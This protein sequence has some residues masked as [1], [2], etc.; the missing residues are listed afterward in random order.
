MNPIYR[1]FLGYTGNLAAQDW[2]D[3]QPGMA[4]NNRGELFER[5]GRNTSGKVSI[6]AGTDMLVRFD[7]PGETDT[8]A[9]Y[10]K[11]DVCLGMTYFTP[12]YTPPAGTE[13]IRYCI[14]GEAY[15][16]V[17]FCAGR[18]TLPVYKDDLAVEYA[19]ESGEQFF[20]AKL[21]GSL[22][23]LG[24]DY[25]AIDGAPF[26]TRFILDITGSTDGGKTWQEVFKGQFY[27]T[28]C[29]FD[30]DNA[31]VE[32]EPEVRDEY[33]DVL[34]GLEN[35]YNLIKLAP[36]VRKLMYYKRPMV[37]VY[38]MGSSKITCILGEILNWETDATATTSNSDL[39]DKFFFERTAG[40]IE[41]DLTY[42]RSTNNF[43][44][45]VGTYAGN[46]IFQDGNT[47]STTWQADL[48]SNNREYYLHVKSYYQADYNTFYL[49]C[50]LLKAN[51]EQIAYK[52]QIT[53]ANPLDSR[54]FNLDLGITDCNALIKLIYTRLVC[55]TTT[56]EGVPTSPIP[57]DDITLSG[58]KN[59]HY[60]VKYLL[61]NS[62]ISA[63]YSETPTEWG[64]RSDG[65][66][67]LP[68]DDSGLFL[69]LDESSWGNASMWFKP[70]PTNAAIERNGRASYTL[71]D[72]Y[73]V[74]DSIAV[75]LKQ[76]APGITHEATEEYSE[77]FYGE[78]TGY[79]KEVQLLLTQK[80]NITRSDYTQAA[81]NSSITLR[82]LLDMFKNVFRAYW[83]IED[84]KLRIEGIDYFRNGGSYDNAPEVGIDL[85]QMRNTRNGK[86]WSLGTSKYKFEKVDM[87]ERYEFGWMDEVSEPF[88][89]LPL[90]VLS[91]YVS[92]GK[93]EEINVSNFTSDIDYMLLNPGEISNDGFALFYAVAGEAIDTGIGAVELSAEN[94][95]S[96]K[97]IPVDG[98]FQGVQAEADIS[99]LV[100]GSASLVFLDGSGNALSPEYPIGAGGARYKVDCRIPQAAASVAI[101]ATGTVTAYFYGLLAYGL[102]QLPFVNVTM[103]GVEY[104]LQNGNLAF[105]SLQEAYWRRDMPAPK[106][107]INGRETEA[108][109]IEKKK[110]QEVTYPAP[111]MTCDPSKLVRTGIGDGQIKETSITLSSLTAKTTL[112]Y[113][114]E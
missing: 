70:D 109:S 90:E 82:Q 24:R 6:P 7:L 17:E 80:T 32:V 18:Y 101:R 33:T 25:A 85:T 38:V 84:G 42:S 76:F 28:D 41:A 94:G 9:A 74:A 27:K 58:N 45:L 46:I 54:V 69:P 3:E 50:A 14:Y 2:P 10:G 93:K 20:R 23:F 40:T 19:Q 8:I 11:G 114:T 103:D 83:F 34:A 53:R 88:K 112:K 61:D 30:V 113:D 44:G 72:A 66:Y 68:P 95:I 4:I 15:G 96:S 67:Y 104:S 5:E 43:P 29:E 71:K 110:T 111:G 97:T 12:T 52:A 87:A 26:D 98:T 105:A 59:Y 22:T 60:A 36:Q 86:P 92:K 75:L 56:V 89:G 99:L 62:Y 57:S 51:G 48:Y 13:Y 31:I 21:S 108:L 47:L 79:G 16:S 107:K 64:M 39:R 63:R 91:P 35:E 106:L 1:F 65:N 49:D 102:P 81:Q 37:Q 78:R 55:D 73:L 100:G 77:Y